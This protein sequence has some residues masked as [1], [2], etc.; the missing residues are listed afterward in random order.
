MSPKPIIQRKVTWAVNSGF[1]TIRQ[2][3]AEARIKKWSPIKRERLESFLFSIEKVQTETIEM[4][5]LT[6]K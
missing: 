3:R 1:P 2:L 6:E 5:A 4:T